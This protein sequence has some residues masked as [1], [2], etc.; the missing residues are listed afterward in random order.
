MFFLLVKSKWILNF[1]HL[2]LIVSWSDEALLCIIKKKVLGLGSS[3][4]FKRAL[5]ELGFKYSEL[6]ISISFKSLEYVD[7][8]KNFIKFLDCSILILSSPW[9]V[10][11]KKKLGCT[12]F[13]INFKEWLFKFI[14][15]FFV[16]YLSF[17]SSDNKKFIKW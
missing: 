12:L 10:S 15:N 13:W 4:D 6:S 9:L 8:F 3:N 11:N 16:I 2:D 17:S 7:L 14:S 5:E 1:I